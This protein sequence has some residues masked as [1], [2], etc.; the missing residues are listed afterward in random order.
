[1]RLAAQEL[2]PAGANPPRR[3]TQA[4]P[5]QHGRDRRGGDADP[6]QL[7]PDAHVAPGG[8]S[9]ASRLIRRRLGRKRGTTGPGTATSPTSLQQRPVPAAKRLRAHAKQD[10]RSGG[11]RPLTA[12]SK[13]RSAVAY[14]GRFPPRLRIASW[15]RRTTISS[16]RSPPP[17]ASNRTT[18]HKSRYSKRVSAARSLNRFRGDHQH[19]RPGR[20]EFLYPTGGP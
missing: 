17:R 20:I 7:T 12:A 9:L 5:A 19:G 16:S 10:H 15:W 3:R 6:E 1:V 2:R 4:R 11:S 13:A 14:R 8:F 18:P